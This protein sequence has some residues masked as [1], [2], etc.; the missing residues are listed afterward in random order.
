MHR[1]ELNSRN[2]HAANQQYSARAKEHRGS[3]LVPFA[4]VVGLVLVFAMSLY[5]LPDNTGLGKLL[6]SGMLASQA[7]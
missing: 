2:L 6:R 5:L 4:Y 7:S 1:N 3:R